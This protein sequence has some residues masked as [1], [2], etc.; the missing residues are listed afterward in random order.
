MSNARWQTYWRG[1]DQ[2][3]HRYE[4]IQWLQFYAGELALYF[5]EEPVRTL[6]LGCGNGDITGLLKDHWAGYTGTDFS[7]A[8]LA[9]YKQRDP[10]ADLVCADAARLPFGG[11]GYGLIFSNGVCQYLDEVQLRNN[12]Q[13]VYALLKPGGVYLIGNI[14]DAQ[15][16]L[17]YYAGGLRS[18]RPISWPGLGRKLFANWVKRND[19]IGHWYTRQSIADLANEY[20]FTC[21]TFSSA[22]YEYRFHARLQKEPGLD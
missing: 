4:D 13:E 21:Q 14:P 22:S 3:Q 2:A 8:M 9:K 6:E 12:L 10:Q 1:I 15:L 17:L 11:G 19:G 5:P 7:P 16:R 18:D 20:H